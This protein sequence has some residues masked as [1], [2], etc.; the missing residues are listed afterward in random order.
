MR[1]A[2]TGGSG[3]IGQAI[4]A[5]LVAAGHDVLVGDRVPAQPPGARFRLIDLES[6]GEAVDVLD[7]CDAVVHAAAVPRPGGVPDH[8][9]FRSNMSTLFNVLEACRVHRIRRFVW[10]SS[11]STLGIPF[12]YRPIPIHALP[13]DE[14]HPL[15]P[16]DPYAL[17]KALGEQLVA[18][19]AQRCHLT[20][21]SLRV[22]WAHTPE[23]FARL[24]VPFWHDPAAGA[25]NCWSYVD[26]RDVGR[27]AALA[28]Q[29]DTAG[30][31]ACFISAPDTC[32]PITTRE[33]VATY[34]PHAPPP[35]AALAPFGALFDTRRARELFGFEARHRWESYGLGDRSAVSA[36]HRER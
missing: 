29:C 11:M 23:S 21:I 24:L 6:F 7:G 13:F 9:L 15:D 31:H 12:H 8:V 19:Y 2:V 33:L 30:H 22:V 20:A 4:V 36:G 10:T 25:T 27:A 18:A 1:I 16:Q 35:H 14:Q 32:M 5:A 34:L 26:T 28:L 3:H 17:S